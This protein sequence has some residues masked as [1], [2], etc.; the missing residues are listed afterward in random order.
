MP[1]EGDPCRPISRARGSVMSGS[2]RI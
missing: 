2:Y 1:K